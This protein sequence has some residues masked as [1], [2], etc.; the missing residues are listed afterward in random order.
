MQLTTGDRA[1]VTMDHDAPPGFGLTMDPTI[2]N[3]SRRRPVSPIPATRRAAGE[4][5]PGGGACI[6]Q[7]S[8]TTPTLPDITTVRPQAA[9]SAD[10][11]D[12]DVFSSLAGT[13]LRNHLEE[14]PGGPQ[15]RGGTS[16]EGLPTLYSTATSGRGVA[17]ES[18]RSPPISREAELSHSAGSAGPS[19]FQ[20][21]SVVSPAPVA[22]PSMGELNMIL[23]T[24]QTLVPEFPKLDPGDPSTRARRFQQWLLQVTQSLEPAGSHVAAWWSWVLT[25]A[26][27]AH[28]VMTIRPVDQ[29]ENIIPREA[30]PLQFVQVESWLRPRIFACIPKTQREWVYLRA[31][32]GVVDPS[33]VLLFYA[34][35]FF[36][37]GSPDERD[38][39]MRRV[40]NPSV[41][42]HAGSAHIE[43]IRWR[44]D[45]RRLSALGC[46]P[47]D[48]MLRYRA[49]LFHLQQCLRQSWAAAEFAVEP[50]QEPAGSP[51]C[52]HSSGSDGG[53]PIRRHGALSSRDPRWGFVEPGISAHGQP[54]GPSAADQGVRQEASGG[55][56]GVNRRSSPTEHRRRWLLGSPAP[57]PTGHSPATTGRRVSAPVASAATSI[58][59][60]FP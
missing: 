4:T 34:Y 16:L 57:C 18:A 3:F 6:V 48:L 37:P 23:K 25:T 20:S 30:F 8:A 28:R 52:D 46:Y 36:A 33:N 47:P 26:E 32:Q 24:L 29:R 54:K 44:A 53:V 31:Q 55:S 56:E 10:D 41:C 15:G 2:G 42:I 51:S 39:L 38:S 14:I 50:A 11:G 22:T 45:I 40:L 35:K 49:L 59:S 27:Q 19:T 60:A 13:R 12:S 9:L 17:P 58:M 21:M 5:P 43:H 1:T 7:Y